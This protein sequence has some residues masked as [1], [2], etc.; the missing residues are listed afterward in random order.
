MMAYP[1]YYNPYPQNYYTPPMQD[2]LA[3]LRQP[4]QP[5][6]QAQQPMQQQNQQQVASPIQWVQGEE[7]A[8]AFLVTAGNTV[9]LM[10][11][12]GN[13]FYLK[14]AD[15]SGMPLPLRIF[16]YTERIAAPKQAPQAMPNVDYIT[17]QEFEQF[18]SRVEA[19]MQKP[20]KATPIK[21]DAQDGKSNL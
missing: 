9:L 15:A 16:D 5:I 13:S 10:D 7:G 1:N 2:Q 8:K 11:S 14:S 4:Y 17:R 12:D 20:K 3:Q 19:M 18:A 21:E 6:Q